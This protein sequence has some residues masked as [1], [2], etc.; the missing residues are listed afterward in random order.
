MNRVCSLS[1]STPHYPPL[2]RTVYRRLLG[3]F[4][5]PWTAP[6]PA[7][8][9]IRNSARREWK[10]LT[11]NIVTNFI[12][13]LSEGATL[14]VI[15]LAVNLM[16]A[17][18]SDNGGRPPFQGMF[19][20]IPGIG[21]WLQSQLLSS[22]GRSTLFVVLIMSAL[23]LQV[24]MSLTS[25]LNTVSAGILGQRFSSQITAIIHKRILS[26]SFSCASRFQ[27]GDLLY[28]LGTGGVTVRSQITTTN[29]LLTNTLQFIVYLLI[30]ITISPW[31]LLV[32]IGMAG[33][34]T[35]VA[36]KVI[37][38]IR[39]QSESLTEI[40]V[41]LSSEQ[42][43]HIQ[44][45]RLL[46]SSGQ[47]ANAARGT[48]RLLTQQERVGSRMV[49][50]N[51]VVSPISNLLPIIAIS[52]IAIASVAFLKDRQSGILPSL[53]AFVLALQ[54]LNMRLGAINNDMSNFALNSSQIARLNG[55][56]SDEGKEFI[57]TGGEEFQSLQREITLSDVS[58]RYN[59]DADFVLQ[60]INLRIPRGKTIALV[61]PSGA[62]KS[63]LA[64]LLVGLYDP[65][66]GNILI[67]GVDLKHYELS[68]WQQRLGVV[69]QDTFLLNASIGMNISYGCPWATQQD[70]QAAAVMAQAAGF[71]SELPDSYDTLIGE[72]G[73]RLSGG[74][75]QR[76]SLARAI[77]RKP[78][79]MILDEATSAL[80]S[81]SEHLVQQAIERFENNHTV[82]VIAHRLST[83]INAD[84]ICVMESGRIV[85]RGTHREL[86]RS[87][88]TYAALWNRQSKTTVEKQAVEAISSNL[89][90]A[91]DT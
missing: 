36:K 73:Y 69:S 43:E 70:I 54:R 27:V 57:R 59:S 66:I 88:G 86:I 84:L 85:E 19:Q 63:S 30:L 20:S 48:E 3:R 35:F 18:L 58:L 77:L 10:L 76:I 74:Q 17:N 40:S 4:I 67:D 65:T 5:A 80:D 64:D 31:L 53:V 6:T 78:E 37:P 15:F 47:L 22:E 1:T 29:S 50:T 51:S 11:I 45:L 68:S 7:A 82:L 61:G 89:S 14:G 41:A 24:L 38:K 13:S 81:H 91:T 52:I 49:M 56:L 32:A 42:T 23:A 75:R 34:M 46:H 83:I 72:R 39:R 55:I 16:T 71:I 87:N 60:N 25:Y 26:L 90:A 9:L 62:G 8:R 12:S 79:L 33:A 44:C 21:G 2:L 28:Y